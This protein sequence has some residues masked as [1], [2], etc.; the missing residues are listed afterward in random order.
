M[1]REHIDS[2]EAFDA[3]EQAAY[4]YEAIC[5]CDCDC[6]CDWY[7]F[8]RYL[9]EHEMT[10]VVR[11]ESVASSWKWNRYQR[12]QEL[13]F[14]IKMR[15]VGAPKEAPSLVTFPSRGRFSEGIEEGQEF[16]IT[17]KFKAYNSYQDELQA[18]VTH[19]KKI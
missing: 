1:T 8:E 19:C 10:V 11:V 7:E 16:P 14:V 18:V 3:N 5:D 17:C 4:E 13:R 6:D 15:E 2:R 12:R 9:D